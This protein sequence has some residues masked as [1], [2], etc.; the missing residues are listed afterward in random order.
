MSETKIPWYWKNFSFANA[1]ALKGKYVYIRDLADC[2][3]YEKALIL[4]HEAFHI[5]RQQR[6]G[7]FKYL[8]R[9]G[10]SRKFRAFE[11]THAYIR[12]MEFKHIMG[13]LK[14]N[15]AAV[16]TDVIDDN[17]RIGSNRTQVFVDLCVAYM[18]I[19]A[20]KKNVVADWI[21]EWGGLK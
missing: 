1:V 8:V 16:Y 17:Y 6:I 13:T 10:T 7:W 11:E 5:Q 3:P 15:A 21:D 2:E 12:T 19:L 14:K 9:Y 18:H 4:V 20:D